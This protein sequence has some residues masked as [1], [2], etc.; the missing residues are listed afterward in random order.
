MPTL[1]ERPSRGEISPAKK[2][3][4]TAS[5]ST[6]RS[7]RNSMAAADAIEVR[8]SIEAKGDPEPGDVEMED[9][10]GS[11]PRDTEDPEADADADADADMDAEGEVDADG[12]ADEDEDEDDG[13]AMQQD[14]SSRDMLQLIRETSEY[15]CRYT[16][17]VDGEDHEIAGGFQR[18]VNKR[19]LP[20]YFEVI[21]EPMAFSTIR[22][23]LGKKTYTGFN[24]FVRDVM[25]I[26]HNAQVYN[27]PSA[28]I[29]SDA[30]RLQ[31]VFKD[32]LDEM[33]KK[34]QI[35]AAEA[36]LPDL[37]PLPEFEDSPPP[38]E[39]EE[40]EE[41]EEED[42]EEDEDEED[43]DSDDEGG[44][45]RKRRR[46]GR[47]SRGGRRN[48][49]DDDDDAHKRRGRPPKVLTPLEARINELLRGLRRFKNESGQLRI[50]HF[51]R[52]PDKSE[53]PDYYT[54]IRNPMALD[55]IKKKY[56]RKKYTTLDQVMQDLEL[57]FENAK[58]YN[59]EGSEVYE[60]AVELQKQARAIAEEEK[61]KPDD[62]FRDED[63]KLPLSHI[64]YKGELWRVGDWVH[65]RNPN[66]LTK[67]IVAQLYRIWSD[68]GGQRW[69]NACWYYRPEQTVH[70]YDKHFYENEVVKTGQYRDHR[71]EEV[72]DRCF[73]MFI[74]R[75][76]K[77]RPRGLPADKMVYL[78]EARYNEEKFR[79]NKI[80]TWTSCLPDEV[81]D[82]DYEMDMFDVARNVK[83]HPSPIKH[84][85]QADA[86]ETDPLPKPTWRSLNAPPLIGA[87]HRRPREANLLSGTAH[88][89]VTVANRHQKDSP[90]PEPIPQPRLVAQ[91][92]VPV[93]L[94]L[95]MGPSH[96]PS[97]V[98]HPPGY[99]PGVPPPAPSPVPIPSPNHHYM[100]QFA[101]RPGPPP[102]LHPQHLQPHPHQQP[103]QQH[104]QPPPMPMH[105]PH[106]VLQ[107]QMQPSPHFA[108]QS[109]AQPYGAQP[110]VPQPVH[111]QSPA[112]IAPAFEP[113]HRPVHPA[114]SLTP[115][116]P[117]MAPAPNT[118]V[119]PQANAHAGN[120]YNAP[121]PPE[122]YTLAEEVDAA[123]GED[124]R[125]QFQRDEQ[126]RVL[127]FT[128]PPLKRPSNG[129]AEQY[130]GLGHSVS[131]LANINQIRE[132]RRRKRKE[133]DDALAMEQAAN[134]KQASLEAEARKKETEAEQKAQAELIENAILGWCA[135]MNQG[136]QLIEESLGGW[137]ALTEQ[138][139]EAN[140]GKTPK[141]LL[142]KNLE[143]FYEDLLKRGEITE[144]QKK[145]MEDTF[146]HRR[147]LTDV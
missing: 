123:I 19:S 55:L 74:T 127:F 142:A 33:V 69:V 10:D 61:A 66:D 62:Q 109:Y 43:D 57:M 106:P 14:D 144:A 7:H 30:G 131:H 16:I 108:P 145:D 80:K 9:A 34:G 45:R 59:E 147:H 96:R 48:R 46:G 3:S 21:K 58:E 38:D 91:G 36:E 140:K 95:S 64:E 119:L 118:A 121:R 6:P 103:H 37:G 94:P 52:L 97:N 44:R 90:P 125:K 104:Q 73:V 107:P 141:E 122:V 68:A 79:F 85:L 29:F 77:G 53:L 39:E 26:C 12:E 35:T 89:N 1:R 143:W 42:E 76:G 11:A 63:G 31:Q 51:E 102:A 72:E 128:A 99:H 15:L 132:E 24:E 4:P 124:V 78:C 22:A 146:I 98:G 110:Q 2:P 40:E 137:K 49:D 70:R 32:K 84:L 133:R 25:R 82:R 111:Y 129:V 113:H 135:G 92:P 115:A 112:Q 8:E 130:A 5:R 13:D 65:I 120:V 27:R 28:P 87:V 134:K 81:R 47:P 116:R 126:G 50:L 20:D 139:R 88:G 56:K 138:A 67:P 75:Y 18:L 101:P 23:K 41:E 114:P 71:I 86:K 117:P 17:K 105:V 136:T 100:Q 60:D 83:K 93:P 54:A